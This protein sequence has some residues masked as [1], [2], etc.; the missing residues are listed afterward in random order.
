MSADTHLLHDLKKADL[1]YA[2]DATKGITRKKESGTIVYFDTEG[3]KITSESVLERIKNLVIPP[4]WN[5]AWIC[6]SP[7]G[8]LQATGLDEKGRKQYI[9][10]MD[11]KKQMQENK[12]NKMV[13][14]AQVLPKIRQKIYKDMSNDELDKE[15][16]IATVVWLL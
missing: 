12:F 7:T 3:K 11:W 8:Y 9:Y 2:T 4:A 5:N 1:R 13:D 6:P 10:H 16:I 15:K 14:F